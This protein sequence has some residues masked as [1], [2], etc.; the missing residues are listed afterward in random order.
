MENQLKPKSAVNVEE[1]PYGQYA[2]SY[3][4]VHPS[5]SIVT[6]IDTGTGLKD[7]F[8]FIEEEILRKEHGG[9][10]DAEK[11]WTFQVI[12]THTHFDHIGSATNHLGPEGHPRTYSLS[13]S[14]AFPSF[15]LPSTNT[16]AP[17]PP[18]SSNSSNPLPVT[19]WLPDHTQTPSPSNLHVIHTPGHTPD[20]IT[21]GDTELNVLFVGDHFHP[22][23]PVDLTCPGADVDE[24]AKSVEKIEV[25]LKDH[26][27]VSATDGDGE[28]QERWVLACGHVEPR[29]DA[30]E[31]IA[32]AK[33]A[34]ERYRKGESEPDP[35]EEGVVFAWDSQLKLGLR[36][37]VRV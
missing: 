5:E 25:W 33:E 6:V 32:M 31:A 37:R 14:N 23:T 10:G 21:L 34:L 15:G 11:K 19:L 8:E 22:W 1:D 20:G 4:K 24:Y 16:L 3:V 7:I 17:T 13:L 29:W 28:G 12:C 35:D 26:G 9:D 18:N 36:I 30:M 2:H 27:G